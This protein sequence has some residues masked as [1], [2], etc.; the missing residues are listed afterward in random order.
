MTQRPTD[1][2]SWFEISV[3]VL[4]F[5]YVRFWVGPIVLGPASNSQI[6]SERLGLKVG[7][8]ILDR[9]GTEI[10]VIDII[11]FYKETRRRIRRN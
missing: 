10:S 7:P 4:R 11:N 9:L 8:Y 2:P 3:L 1:R 6:D 5:I